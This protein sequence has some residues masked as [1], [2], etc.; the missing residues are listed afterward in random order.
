M[1]PPSRVVC[2]QIARRRV[3][4][5]LFDASPGLPSHAERNAV[6]A[7]YNVAE[8]LPV[9]RKMMQAWT[10]YL[11]ALKTSADVIPLLKQAWKPRP[12]Q[13]SARASPHLKAP[14]GGDGL[15][16]TEP[17]ESTELRRSLLRARGRRIRDELAWRDAFSVEAVTCDR[18]YKGKG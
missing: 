17:N 15:A 5:P 4:D 13:T 6:S 3:G 18:R 8:H 10:D 14:S 7:A 12:K 9:R 11:V 2:R 1:G 16:G